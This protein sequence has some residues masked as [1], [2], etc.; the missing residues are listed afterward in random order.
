MLSLLLAKSF[1]LEVDIFLPTYWTFFAL[2]HPP[3]D[4]LR[5]ELMPTV[6]YKFLGHHLDVCQTD[7]ALKL[8]VV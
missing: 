3:E 1:P 5:M 2:L 8:L 4:A 7:G 6:Q